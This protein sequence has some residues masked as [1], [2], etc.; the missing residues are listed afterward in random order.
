MRARNQIFKELVKCSQQ[1]YPPSEVTTLLPENYNGILVTV[2][3][4]SNYN[5]AKYHLSGPL[6]IISSADKNLCNM[7]IA[8]S[9]IAKDSSGTMHLTQKL[10]NVKLRKGEFSV[11]MIRQGERVKQYIKNCT[12]C[13]KENAGHVAVQICKSWPLDKTSIENGLF[14]CIQLDIIGPFYHKSG[15]I[16]RS[17]AV[18]KVWIVTFV[19]QLSGAVSFQLMENYSTAAFIR[20]FENH[21]HAHRMP[22][23]V[24]SDAGTQI[25]ASTRV[26]TRS[27]SEE[28]QHES[29]DQIDIMGD[30][31]KRFKSIEWH[32]APVEAQ[33]YNGRVEAFNKQIKRLLR[34]QLGLIRKQPISEFQSIFDI[35]SYF[36]KICG[37]LN[38]RP[39]IFNEDNFVTIKDILFPTLQQDTEVSVQSFSDCVHDKFKLF[40]QLFEHEVVLGNYQRSGSRSRTNKIDIKDKDFVLIRYPSRPGTYRY[41]R[42][43]KIVSA[44]RAKILILRRKSENKGKCEPQV[45]DTQNIIL[46]KR[47]S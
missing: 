46:L 27:Q 33:H 17:N 31:L 36:H 28:H 9:H 19:C 42:V 11:H 15:S 8:F 30:A 2:N 7:L 25:K 44:H 35:N 6:P 14:H 47:H 10:T 43:I 13:R 4:L 26:I 40:V 16:T 21:C 22:K 38:D 41:G 34:T 29:L 12:V 37:L 32:V 45:M 20:S 3:R 5:L 18:R 23:V 39:I 24:T 1:Y